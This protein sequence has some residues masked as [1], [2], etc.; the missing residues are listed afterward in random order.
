MLPYALEPLREERD[1]RHGDG[2]VD[3][4]EQDVHDYLLSYRPQGATSRFRR[5]RSP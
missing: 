5:S 2:R 3:L 4:L 1:V